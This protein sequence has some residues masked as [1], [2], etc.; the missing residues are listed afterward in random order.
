MG[1]NYYLVRDGANKC[2]HCGRSDNQEKIH[3]GKSSAGW[4]FSLHVI[5][6]MNINSLDDW[7]RELVSGTIKNEYGDTI[8]FYELIANITD[9][10]HGVPFEERE[11]GG[12]FHPYINEA[13]FHAKN[14]SQRGPNG[15]LRHRIDGAHCVGHGEGTWDYIIGD[16]S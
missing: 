5:P 12:G 8:P 1:T 9:R 3:I 6:E 16:F 11:W 4:C 7:K 2:E 10:G 13:D 15:M 14:H